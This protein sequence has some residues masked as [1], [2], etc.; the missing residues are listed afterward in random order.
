MFVASRLQQNVVF[1]QVALPLLE[2]LSVI[3]SRSVR[4]A[5]PKRA[6]KLIWS[7]LTKQCRQVG[8]TGYLLDRYLDFEDPYREVILD[9]KQ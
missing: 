5:P 6:S 8:P 3:L 2:T 9:D 7:S 4:F 1:S